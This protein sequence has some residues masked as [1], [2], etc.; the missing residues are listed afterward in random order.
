MSRALVASRPAAQ[1]V[2]PVLKRGLMQKAAAGLDLTSAVRD[3]AS[4]AREYGEVRE[5]ERTRRQA[6]AS[7]ER[8]ELARI[9]TQRELVL[10]ALDRAFDERAV[11]F[12]HLFDALDTALESGEPGQV[13][14]VTGAITALA[15]AN[16]FVA[17][18][19]VAS[20]QAAAADPDHVWSL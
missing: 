6:I 17:L 4:A 12:R 20:V 10:G 1:L 14:A 5:R 19:D 18:R 13:G 3:I 2:A 11:A 15:A 8:V 16:P 7:A 9:A